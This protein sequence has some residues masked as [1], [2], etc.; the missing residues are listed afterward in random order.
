M[1]Q[2]WFA[3]LSFFNDAMEMIY[4]GEVQ[5]SKTISGL[6]MARRWLKTD[7][8]KTFNALT[9]PLSES[10]NACLSLADTA[11]DM[12][13]FALK[14]SFTLFRPWPILSPSYEYQAPLLSIIPSSTPMS[15]SSPVRDIPSPYMISNSASLKGGAS[16]FL[17]TFTRE[18][19]RSPD[20][21]WWRRWA[22]YQAW[23]MNR[24]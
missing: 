6:F 5:D 10:P 23:Q 3:L 14:N 1:F 16:L 9:Y 13:G 21:P 20:L 24:T 22:W 17:T 19:P 2:A 8:S 4:K 12:S 7:K 15:R 11:L 18:R